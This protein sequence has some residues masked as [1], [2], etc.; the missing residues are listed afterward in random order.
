MTALF[1]TLSRMF[2]ISCYSF[3][4]LALSRFLHF[5]N[6]MGVKWYIVVVL[7]SLSLIPNGFE[8]IS[9]LLIFWVSYTANC[10]FITLPIFFLWLLPF[11]FS[12]SNWRNYFHNLVIN[13]LCVFDF[14]SASFLSFIC[15]LTFPMGFFFEQNF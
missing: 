13:P 11:F 5:A 1:H 15:L 9:C 6:L 8:H 7:I 4:H 2:P 10:F 12:F 3:Q 14:L